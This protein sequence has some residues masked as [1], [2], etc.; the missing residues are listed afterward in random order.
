MLGFAVGLVGMPVMATGATQKS[1][2]S[3]ATAGI[4]PADTCA[5]KPA[6]SDCWKNLSNKP[7][8]FFWSQGS[9][10]ETLTWTG[11]CKQGMA[12]GKGILTYIWP[13]EQVAGEGNLVDG[14]QQG[15]WVWRVSNGIQEEGVYTDGKRTG[16]WRFKW[17]DGS[18]GE[19]TMLGDDMQG[20]WIVR[21][22]NG[23]IEKRNYVKGEQQ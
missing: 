1:A 18:T 11:E 2:P 10:D 22:P 3:A 13:K 15:H 9:G 5:A 19:G 8:C 16:R 17:P 23:K 20:E 14:K 12:Q 6:G 4:N 21:L 7:G